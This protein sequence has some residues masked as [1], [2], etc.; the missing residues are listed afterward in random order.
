MTTVYLGLGSNIDPARHLPLGLRAVAELLGSLRCSPIY[1]GAAIGFDGDPFWNLVVGAETKL[2]VGELQRALREIEYRH[3]RAVNA[4]RFSPRV[5]DI[6]ILTHGDSVGVI[7]GVELPRA[8]IVQNAF[9][10]RPLAE[11]AG[12]LKHPALGI[13][14]AAL[15][16]AFDQGSQP[17]TRVEF[18]GAASA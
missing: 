8:E 12:D 10:L 15:W 7:D 2:S 14:Y 18:A 11:L 1:E 6:D 13:S 17:L 5:L 3:G 4:P 16:E 9:V